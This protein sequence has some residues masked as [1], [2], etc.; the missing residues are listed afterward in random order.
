MEEPKSPPKTTIPPETREKSPELGEIQ[1]KI[2]TDRLEEIKRAMRALSDLNVTTI[3][4]FI[5]EFTDLAD[6]LNDTPPSF[7]LLDEITGLPAED[8]LHLN[9]MIKFIKSFKDTDVQRTLL[10][11][12]ADVY[13][14]DIVMSYIGSI[15]DVFGSLKP[16]ATARTPM[17]TL[18]VEEGLR[19]DDDLMPHTPMREDDEETEDIEPTPQVA[20][21]SKAHAAAKQTPPKK[22][23]Q[24]KPKKKVPAQ[25]T[26]PDI[27]AP[28][29]TSGKKKSKGSTPKHAKKD[30]APSSADI[31]RTFITSYLE[32]MK[33]GI[34]VTN[35]DPDHMAEKINSTP[36]ATNHEGADLPDFFMLGKINLYHGLQ[37]HKALHIGDSYYLPEAVDT[38]VNGVCHPKAG[39]KPLE[40]IF[41]TS[42]C[43]L[44]AIQN[45][46]N[47]YP[48]DDAAVE[49]FLGCFNGT[50]AALLA[51]IPELHRRNI[52]APPTAFY[53]EAH[54]GLLL[55][56]L[57]MIIEHELYLITS[58]HAIKLGDEYITTSPISDKSFELYMEPLTN[59]DGTVSERAAIRLINTLLA[60]Y[61]A[62]HDVTEDPNEPGTSRMV[63]RKDMIR[64]FSLNVTIDH[65]DYPVAYYVN[66][67]YKL[68][69]T[70]S[71]EAR[72]FFLRVI[73]EFQAFIY[74]GGYNLPYTCR[75]THYARIVK[76]HMEEIEI[77]TVFE[78][79]PE[80]VKGLSCKQ[81]R[82][83][84]P[85]NRHKVEVFRL[86]YVS[87]SFV[88]PSTVAYSMLFSQQRLN[89]STMTEAQ[90][91]AMG[92]IFNLN[93]PSLH[94]RDF[95][96]TSSRVNGLRRT[97]LAM[98]GAI[99]SDET[100]TFEK[101][102]DCK[103]KLFPK[104]RPDLSFSVYASLSN[105]C[106]VF[107]TMTLG[108]NTYLVV[109][110]TI[111]IMYHNTHKYGPKAPHLILHKPDADGR[112]YVIVETT[113]Y[114]SHEHTTRLNRTWRLLNDTNAAFTVEDLLRSAGIPIE[115]FL[116][117]CCRVSESI[118]DAKKKRTEMG[119]RIT[120][121]GLNSQL[122]T[123][124]GRLM[125]LWQYALALHTL[126]GPN[127]I[128]KVMPAV[129]DAGM[130]IKI[131]N[132]TFGVNFDKEGRN[133]F[134]FIDD[135]QADAEP[136]CVRFK[137]N[138]EEGRGPYGYL[139]SRMKG[140][141]YDERMANPSLRNADQLADVSTRASF[142]EKDGVSAGK[143]DLL[144]SSLSVRVAEPGTTKA[145]KAATAA[146]NYVIPSW[147]TPIVA[148]TTA[149]PKK[150]KR[151][152]EEAP[153][154][155]PKQK[156][157]KQKKA[158][159]RPAEETHIAE[160]KQKKPKQTPTIIEKTA[161]I[162]EQAAKT[163][164]DIA[165]AANKGK[166]PAKEDTDD[167]MEDVQ[168]EPT[169]SQPLTM[170]A[171]AALAG[172]TDD[173]HI[174]A[175]QSDVDRIV[176][177]P[178]RSELPSMASGA[179]RLGDH[180]AFSVVG[181][182]VETSTDNAGMFDPEKIMEEFE[183]DSIDP[184]DFA[185]PEEYEC[186]V[187]AAAV[188]VVLPLL[189]LNYYVGRELELLNK[190]NKALADYRNASVVIE[191]GR[192]VDAISRKKATFNSDV[193]RLIETRQNAYECARELVELRREGKEAGATQG[194]DMNEV[195]VDGNRVLNARLIEFFKP[196]KNGGPSARALLMKKIIA[197]T[198]VFTLNDART[199]DSSDRFVEYN[200]LSHFTSKD[201]LEKGE[202]MP[203]MP[204]RK[205]AMI[206]LFTE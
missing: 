15:N 38:D 113:N 32:H 2:P 17:V 73:D 194:F 8:Q 158:E 153:I 69:S 25:P 161:P 116:Y 154:V 72:A 125:I 139:F 55:L 118:A 143:V 86:S 156:K 122:E 159:K 42:E 126:V 51:C 48:I 106:S 45:I 30:G 104:G 63:P 40:N 7:A 189:R 75:Q 190:L 79:K 70:C 133:G 99:L 147:R 14:L 10:S 36:R 205:V 105:L 66:D 90:L 193:E 121:T 184:K 176:E 33:N 179:T 206:E 146:D 18:P 123:Q 124:I 65:I 196:T 140:L 20:G 54:T 172:R 191:M 188:G 26:S 112:Y 84:Q 76:S 21:S 103:Y 4:E 3:E 89:T 200:I 202:A 46:M 13:T 27:K 47:E 167:E 53:W 135:T 85:D 28:N 93:L 67:M 162:A 203:V 87:A 130:T 98:D 137:Y 100:V 59:D 177:L 163:A 164:A 108:T 110:G 187:T 81:L 128:A 204:P 142:N 58:F 131:F 49:L 132:Y 22:P 61:N 83:D 44:A 127:H 1:H 145:E 43:I 168:P 11:E 149:E 173:D 109:N 152:A 178:A 41:I 120:A 52:D 107:S 198:K 92:K 9:N 50:G 34:D 80:N 37:T 117:L 201:Y 129:G 29:K 19:L 150:K 95:N 114:H 151:P 115:A 56:V 157:P 182:C 138:K 5:K 31:Q 166:Q 71:V 77:E 186:A 165:H 136:I 88:A 39:A 148:A 192:P 96:G 141:R 101:A 183:S 64:F 197:A 23:R 160:P 144:R 169:P 94:F 35:T 97:N 185:T 199:R 155:E 24:R 180:E 195:D 62:F 171:L 91:L 111:S 134:T 16:K 102:I 6:F 12:N 82:G 181:R 119:G 74:D 57:Q 175:G 78:G 170:D 60:S 174:V 68:L